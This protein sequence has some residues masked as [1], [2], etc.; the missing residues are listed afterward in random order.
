MGGG[1][2]FEGKTD[3]L[4]LATRTGSAL[5]RIGPH[6]GRYLHQLNCTERIIKSSR[7]PQTGDHQRRLSG[8]GSW[9]CCSELIKDFLPFN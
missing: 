5:T 7:F 9:P 2:R 1:S 8:R 6:A 4:R 3:T